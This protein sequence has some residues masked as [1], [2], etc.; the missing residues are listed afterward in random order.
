[1]EYFASTEN[2]PRNNWQ[3]ELLI[4]SFKY[5]NCEKNLLITIAENDTFFQP[6]PYNNIVSHEIF[7]ENQNMGRKQGYEPLNDLYFIVWALENKNLNQPFIHIPI[8]VVLNDPNYNYNFDSIYPEVIFK[9]NPF[10]TVDEI[11]KNMGPIWNCL[12]NTKEFYQENLVPI[13]SMM[14]FNNFPM[15]FFY[16][17]ISLIQILSVDQITNKNEIW[18]HTDKAAWAIMLADIREQVSLKE[19]YFLTSNMLSFDT[20]VAFV[21]YEYGMPPVFHKL[22][23]QYKPPEYISCGN[24]FQILSENAPTPNALLVSE[25][26][27][28]I[29]KSQNN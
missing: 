4:E 27:R 19:N 10:L 25:L 1:M 28:K 6:F 16:S 22:M 12:A 11:E 20:N 3:V 15:Q 17:V 2:D 13:G 18:E 26:A 29:L 5:H 23:F 7:F 24:P 21:D 14:G 8:D 9:P